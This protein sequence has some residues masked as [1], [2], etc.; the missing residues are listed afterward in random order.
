MCEGLAAL[1]TPELER[2]VQEFFAARRISLGGNTL[3]RELER[4][5]I[6]VAFR[7]R[8]GAALRAYLARRP[9]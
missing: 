7:E 2:S 1:A 9:S 4:L 5:R 6:A 8:E 3:E